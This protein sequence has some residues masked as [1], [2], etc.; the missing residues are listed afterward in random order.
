MERRHFLVTSATAAQA[1]LAQAP[2]DRVGTAVIGTGNRGSYLLQ[3]VIAQPNAKVTAVCDLKP[4]RLD[5]AA[6]AAAKDNPFT[7]KEWRK[8]IERKD[9][10]AVYVA[11][12]PHLHA[13]MAVA[14]LEAG[15][16]VYCE[17]PVGITPAQVR[18]V[19]RAAKRS[20][21][22]FVSGQQLRSMVQLGTA[23]G[24]IHGGVMGQIYMI[25][26][27]RHASADLPH[28]GSSGDWYFDVSKSGGYLIEQSVHNLD[29]CN[30]VMNAHPVRACGFG[31]NMRYKNEPQGRTIFDN[32]S[33]VFEYPGGVKMEF[34]QNVFHPR[35]MPGGNQLVYIFG[36][37][38]GVDLMYST[39]FYPHTAQGENVEIKAL[40]E[41]VK[42]EPHAHTTAFF[43]LVGGANGKNPADITIGASAAVTAI[44][45]HEAMVKQRVVTWQ[46][47]GVEL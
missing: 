1:V 10:D 33:M 46:E 29:L 18:S 15:K 30:W 14:A 34:T 38:G 47:L 11:T 35:Q 3:G 12:P 45:G 8:V 17:K 43:A 19:V 26:A 44:L 13:E 41:K 42:E 31:G 16:H 32:G 36:E 7:T 6:S 21:K 4:D 27:Q 2:N 23:V 24:K 20:K 28:D 37:K 5:K 9:V 22:V 40:A 39:N 25:K